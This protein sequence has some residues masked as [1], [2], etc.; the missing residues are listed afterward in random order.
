MKAEFEELP[1]VVRDYIVAVMK[2][3]GYRR[4]VRQ[5]VKEELVAHF[6]DALKDCGDGQREERGKELIAEFGD[7]KL[8]GVLLRRGK[9]R[10]RPKWQTAIVRGVGIIAAVFLVYTAW[11]VTGEPKAQT[12]YLAVINQMQ[13]RAK[14]TGLDEDNALVNY[15]KGQKLYVKPD[16]ELM[17]LIMDIRN[18]SHYTHLTDS[19]KGVVSEWL[20]L[21]EPAWEE[22]VAGSRKR[23]FYFELDYE[24]ENKEKSLAAT[25]YPIHE[26]W[27]SLHLVGLCQM[28]M[29]LEQGD[30]DQA[31]EDCFVM[32]R[33]VRHFNENSYWVVD[34]MVGVL[35]N[36][37]TLDGLLYLV[38]TQQLSANELKELQQRLTQLFPGGYPMFSLCVEEMRIMALD[39]MQR[40]FTEDGPGGGHLSPSQLEWAFPGFVERGSEGD[41][42]DALICIGVSMIHAGRDKT[43]AK[44]NEQYDY[45]RKDME[46]SPYESHVSGSYSVNSSNFSMGLSKYRYSLLSM[47]IPIMRGR[48]ESVYQAKTEYEAAIA[49]LALHR[50]NLEKGEYPEGLNELVEAAFLE[51]LPGDPYSDGALVYKRTDG[52]FILYSVGQK[53]IDDGGKVVVDD[54]GYVQKWDYD[55]GDT[56]FWPIGND[57]R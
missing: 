7:V 53:F 21:N 10:C 56:V 18:F 29:A 15:Q 48:V 35:T 38:K 43:M 25:A 40:I 23:Y 34:H 28:R 24:S 27:R 30:V 37:L 36:R 17:E 31:I 20:K 50:W 49:I 33:L 5:E 55:S 1:A 13:K 32:L 6:T 14:L 19:Q 45:I 51:E 8:L 26:F 47:A 39:F 3:M 11:F 22:F 42:F 52:D 9:K 57:G 12:D 44:I 16:E 4:K 2:K 46:M 54:R 41:V